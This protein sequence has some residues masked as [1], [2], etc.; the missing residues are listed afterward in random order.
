MPIRI[1]S[2]V[3][4]VTMDGPTTAVGGQTRHRHRHARPAMP[5]TPSP[6]RW[7]QQD[8][9][10]PAD[11]RG[12]GRTGFRSGWT[13]PPTAWSAAPPDG[14]Q[15][16]PDQPVPPLPAATAT[17][18]GPRTPARW[19]PSGM[20]DTAIMNRDGDPHGHD[21]QQHARGEGAGGETDRRGRAIS[22][23]MMPANASPQPRR[24]PAA[25]I[26]SISRTA[27]ARPNWT[28]AIEAMAIREPVGAGRARACLPFKTRQTIVHGLCW[29]YRSLIVKQSSPWTSRLRTAAGVVPA[30]FDAGGGRYASPDHLHGVPAAGRAGQGTPASQL[31]EPDGRRVRLTPAGRRLA[32][33][34]V[35]ILP[36]STPPCTIW[37]GAEP[38]GT[39][40]HG[41]ATG[42]RVSLL[43]VLADSAGVTPAS[44]VIISEFEPVEVPAARRRRPGPRADLRL[45]PGTGRADSVRVG[46]AV[47]GPL[48]SPALPE[49][50]PGVFR[51]LRLRRRA[52]DRQLRNSADRIAVRTVAC[53]PASP[54]ASPTRIDSPRTGRGSDLRRLRRRPAAAASANPPRVTVLTLP[55]P[56]AVMTAYAVTRRGGTG[57]PPRA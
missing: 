19:S 13:L 36:A 41:F 50:A 24:V 56:G 15:R 25:P 57:W 29:T 54:H 23:R 52:V 40:R 12:Q 27:T 51:A 9:G 47:V 53:W 11:R 18:S 31:I 4:A 43:P 37:T 38:R 30:R 6:T 2:G 49:P 48:G 16:G 1:S 22:S 14:G 46:R 20:C 39:T 7:I 35:E 42:I 44:R 55:G 26:R 45:Q 3:S 32:E 8:V 21:A 17:A 5:S 34:A 33:H 28:H 10:A